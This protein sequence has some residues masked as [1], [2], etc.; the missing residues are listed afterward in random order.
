MP[1][2]TGT[3][4]NGVP[5][6]SVTTPEIVLAASAGLANMPSSSASTV[7][8]MAGTPRRHRRRFKGE[9]MD[10]LKWDDRGGRGDDG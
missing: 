7:M 1:S 8:T 2:D 4:A 5:S 6:A 3:P 9:G 10:H